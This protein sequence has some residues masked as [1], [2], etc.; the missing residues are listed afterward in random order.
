MAIRGMEETVQGFVDSGLAPSTKSTYKQGKKLYLMFCN[1]FS[2]SAPY[3]VT[4]PLLCSF[5]SY[6]GTLH[7]APPTIKTYLAAVKHEHISRGFQDLQGSAALKLVQRGIAR[8]YSFDSN[9]HPTRLPI[10]PSILRGIMSLWEPQQFEFDTIMLWAALCTGFFGLGE[11]TS[12]SSTNYDTRMHITFDDISVDSPVDTKLIAMNI[13]QSKTDQLRAGTVVNLAKTDQDLCPVAA[14]LAY[15][16]VRGDRLGPLFI[17]K[18]G[19]YLTQY[20]LIFHLRQAL[21]RMGLDPS[22][23]AGHSLRIG[24]A[25]SAAT[26]GMEDSTIRALGRWRSNAYHRYIRRPSSDLAAASTSLASLP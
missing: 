15:I 9:S 11:I 2:V 12:P 18:D 22:S 20:M 6:L 14:L 21:S 7:L 19:R 4:K 1:I 17:F 26:S 25:T 10:T 23:F 13:K 8:Q 16:A 5:A 24:A 3:P